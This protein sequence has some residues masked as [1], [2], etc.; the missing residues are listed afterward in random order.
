[1]HAAS[2][3]PLTPPPLVIWVKLLYQLLGQ[4]YHVDCKRSCCRSWAYAFRIARERGFDSRMD[5]RRTG[6]IQTWNMYTSEVELLSCKLVFLLCHF[7]MFS[8]LLFICA[9]K[10]YSGCHS[11]DRVTF[12]WPTRI[13]ERSTGMEPIKTLQLTVSHWPIYDS[14]PWPYVM[15]CCFHYCMNSRVHVLSN[16]S[17]ASIF[18]W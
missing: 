10:V 5:Y 8:S 14:L 15:I 18:R 6:Y 17:L 1:M 9:A 13:Q 4:H 11:S 3:N 7:F 16:N 2:P 12:V